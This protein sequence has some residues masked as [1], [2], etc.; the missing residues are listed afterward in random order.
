MFQFLA[1]LLTAVKAA[2]PYIAAA[3]TVAGIGSAMQSGRQGR[4]AAREQQRLAQAQII[5]E[6]RARIR[7][8]M[9]TQAALSNIAA[10]TGTAESSGVIGAAGSVSSQL[11]G[12]L[13]FSY[14]TE[15]ASL[16]ASGFEERAAKYGTLSQNLFA[17]SDLF[18]RFDAPAPEEPKKIPGVNGAPMNSPGLRYR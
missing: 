10:Q 15:T 8:A 12:A 3:G 11:G 14:G 2:S 5:D 4:R 1:P 7:E 13:G 16:R 18:S 9:I 17:A 6:R